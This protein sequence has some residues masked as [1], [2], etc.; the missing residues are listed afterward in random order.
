MSLLVK[1]MYVEFFFSQFLVP[2]EPPNVSLTNRY[3][4]E[5]LSKK[6]TMEVVGLLIMIM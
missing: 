6:T 3:T 5:A 4:I 2:L 1:S